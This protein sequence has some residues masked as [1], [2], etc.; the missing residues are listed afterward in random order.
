MH[1]G[2]AAP[3]AIAARHG[4]PVAAVRPLPTG[5]AMRNPEPVAGRRHW[6]APPASRLL[7]ILRFFT[8]PAPE[9]WRS[10]VPPS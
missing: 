1:N 3:A 9:P 10:L 4:V 5:V 7:G 2:D 8:G 6:T